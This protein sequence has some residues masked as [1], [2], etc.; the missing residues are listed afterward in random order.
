[1]A[2]HEFYS[3]DEDRLR[4]VLSRNRYGKIL[5]QLPEGLKHFFPE[6]L[7]II[8]KYVKEGTEVHI[9]SSPTFGSCLMDLSLINNYDIVLHFGHAEYPYWKPPPKVKLIDVFSRNTIPDETLNSFINELK[10]RGVERIAL[11]TTAQ[12]P[13]LARDIRERL[14]AE[15]FTVVNNPGKSIVFGCWFSDLPEIRNDVDA[16]AV[17]AGGKFHAIGLGLVTGGNIPVYG[18]DPYLGRCIDY[19][20]EVYRTLKVRYGKIVKAMNAQN[21]LLVVGSA[22]QYR[23]AIVEKVSSELRGRGKEFVKTVATYISQD[24]LLDMD[25]DWVEAI[26]ITSCPRLAL[27]DL[28]S[29]PKPVLTPGEALISVGALPFESYVFPW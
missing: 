21:W 10:G 6:I 3:V 25:N 8:R 18:V 13:H 15:G 1:M 26:V 24:L 9:D 28:S 23:P 16:V 22:G 12:H 27:E 17:V 7:E 11:Y 20:D 2:F 4:S 19:S 29:F 14:D 5:V